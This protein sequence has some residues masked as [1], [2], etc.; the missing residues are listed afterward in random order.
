MLTYDELMNKRKALLEL[1]KIY[2]GALENETDK[3]KRKEIWKLYDANLVKL[4]EVEK[5]ML[6]K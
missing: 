2:L 1:G 3:T 5:Q 4:N 6:P